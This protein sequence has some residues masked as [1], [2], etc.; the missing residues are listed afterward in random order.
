MSS[1]MATGFIIVGAIFFFV[2]VP[3]CIKF[4]C[5]DKALPF[6]ARIQYN[7]VQADE[8]V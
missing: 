5:W 3:T 7:L 4:Y 2:V 8:I 6:S 1:N